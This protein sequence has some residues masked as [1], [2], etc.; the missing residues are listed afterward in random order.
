MRHVHQLESY[1]LGVVVKYYRRIINLQIIH[2]KRCHQERYQL[3]WIE[4]FGWDGRRRGEFGAVV[5]PLCRLP[6]DVLQFDAKKVCRLLVCI[7]EKCLGWE[8]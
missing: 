4:I 8:N 6:D 2:T 3:V 7:A 5:K 1:T